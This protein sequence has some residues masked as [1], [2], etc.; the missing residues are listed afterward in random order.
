M[1]RFQEF[2]GKANLSSLDMMSEMAELNGHPIK[3]AVDDLS[4][5]SY[6]RSG[7]TSSGVESAVFVSEDE[8][9][10]AGGKKGSI[11]IFSTGKSGQVQKISDFQS[12]YY[13]Q[14]APFRP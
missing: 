10:A 12:V 2:L 11:I 7:G 9:K 14:L 5:T 4:S 1:G 6:A 3:V 8:F 13:L